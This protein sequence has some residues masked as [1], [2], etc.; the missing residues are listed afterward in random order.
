MELLIVE[1]QFNGSFIIKSND[2]QYYYLEMKIFIITSV[3]PEN[4]FNYITKYNNFEIYKWNI[5]IGYS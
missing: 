5:D 4:S 2:I 1:Q 3:P